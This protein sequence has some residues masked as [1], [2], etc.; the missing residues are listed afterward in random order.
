MM[1]V[2][3]KNISIVEYK[4]QDGSK[5][6]KYRVRAQIKGRSF[7]QL[8]DEIEQ[9]KAYLAE[10]KSHFGRKGIDEADIAEAK[11]L[12]EFKSPTF[13]FFF[14]LYFAWKHPAPKDKETE[15]ILKKKQRTTYRSFFNTILK[16]KI[17]IYNEDILFDSPQTTQLL[18]SHG[19]KSNL[20]KKTSLSKLK[21]HE[22]NYKVINA[23]IKARL[24]LGKSKI[25]VRKEVSIISCFYRDAL[26]IDTV[27]IKSIEDLKNPCEK[28]DPRLLEKAY[29]EKKAKRIDEEN[30]EKYKN[31]IF[32]EDLDFAYVSLLQY[33]GAFRMSEALGLTWE[34]IDFKKK[35][36]F[37]PQ[38]KTNPRK[39]SM[40][41]D[42]EDLLDTIEEDKT[43]RVGLVLKTQ[44]IYKYQKQIERFRV[45]YGF[46]L[47]THQFRKDAIS[48]M[49]DNVGTGNKILLAQILGY[50]NVKQFATD[51]IE[52]APNTDTIEGVLQTIGHT[53]NSVNITSNN[54]YELPKLTLPPLPKVEK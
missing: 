5:Q 1:A 12:E 10:A 41:K 27:A 29:T 6:V 38:T 22:I 39:V 48:R 8:F 21:L 51:Y 20:A 28:I 16:T 11:A 34:N 30:F 2:L 37:L 33:Y 26:Y 4:N 15:S 52:E 18:V 3:P 32:C 24:A 53:K 50:T 44:T 23:Y 54:Y 35:S 36:I 40:T 49:I 19:F 25:T 9:A 14:E 47:R 42:L 43:K 45:K 13:D 46:E 17:E 31:C 7:D